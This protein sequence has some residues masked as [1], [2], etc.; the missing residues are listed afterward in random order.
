MSRQFFA[1]SDTAA[2]RAGQFGALAVAL[3]GV[4]SFPLLILLATA[5]TVGF[6]GLSVLFLLGLVF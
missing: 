1:M 5:I 4:T 3:K 6:A 2:V